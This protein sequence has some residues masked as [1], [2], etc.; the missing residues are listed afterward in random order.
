MKAYNISRHHSF[1]RF[2]YTSG[3][4]KI[5]KSSSHGRR[6]FCANCGSQIAFRSTDDEATIEI[7]VGTLDEPGAVLPEYHVYCDSQISW[8]ETVDDLP[9]YPGAGPTQD[10]D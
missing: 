3:P 7:N 5:Y 10:E 8:F 9:R 4:P 6:E 2:S 1:D